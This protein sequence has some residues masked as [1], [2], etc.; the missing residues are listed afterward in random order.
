MKEEIELNKEKAL[1]INEVDTGIKSEETDRIVQEELSEEEK[2]A[3]QK[4]LQ[5]EVEA[6]KANTENQVR[7]RELAKQI[8]AINGQKWFSLR[9]FAK[10]VKEPEIQLFQKL[11]LLELFGLVVSKKWRSSTKFN[12]GERVF[13]ITIDNGQQIKAHEDEIRELENSIKWHRERIEELGK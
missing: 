3:E 11:K 13:R 2:I 12:R 7:A 1:D 10:K 8:L 6:F 4:K 9:N 5:E